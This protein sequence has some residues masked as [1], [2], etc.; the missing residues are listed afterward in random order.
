MRIRYAETCNDEYRQ[1]FDR[2][3][4]GRFLL[5]GGDVV[6]C[7]LDDYARWQTDHPDPW[8]LRTSVPDGIVETY[9][10]GDEEYCYFRTVETR[11]TDRTVVGER[12]PEREHAFAVK[13]ALK[14]WMAQPAS[15]EVSTHSSVLPGQALREPTTTSELFV[16]EVRDPFVFPPV[17]VNS[18]PGG[19]YSLRFRLM[20]AL[21]KTPGT[22]YDFQDR[23]ACDEDHAL[24]TV[25][26]AWNDG[27][28]TRR[29]RESVGA[30]PVFSLSEKG[31]FLHDQGRLSMRDQGG[32]DWRDDVWLPG[33][34]L[35]HRYCCPVCGCEA[36]M[37][38]TRRGNLRVECSR[39]PEWYN[40]TGKC[41]GDW[42]AILH[43]GRIT[44]EVTKIDKIRIE[45]DHWK[46]TTQVCFEDS[47]KSEVP[48]AIS[49][50]ELRAKVK[51]YSWF[52]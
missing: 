2:N 10:V 27:L 18:A 29:A 32:E 9:F 1:W 36:S 3:E 24:R 19:M 48:R 43:D 16:G 47:I 12:N 42:F 31:Q 33:D 34:E 20:R 14:R 46:R 50:K 22:W 13:R 37:S 8:L 7:T 39:N 49:R 41:R 6:Q 5:R 17:E 23:L 21:G 45:I 30:H 4:V 51:M 40:G 35:W 15:T 44:L 52:S 28:V 25:E 26:L 11:G 38:W